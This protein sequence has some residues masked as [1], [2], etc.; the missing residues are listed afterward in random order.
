MPSQLDTAEDLIR[1]GKPEQARALLVEAVERGGEEFQ[2][3]DAA[4]ELLVSA[5]FEADAEH[6]VQLYEQSHR[7]PLPWG[8]T[9]EDI[10]RLVKERD[11]GSQLSADRLQFKRL[12][13]WSRG[14][15]SRYLPFDPRIIKHVEITP[16]EIVAEKRFGSVRL[17]WNEVIDC[18]LEKREAFTAVGYTEIKY[19]KRLIVL[20]TPRD[21]LVIDVS[22][23]DPEF[24]HSDLLERTI[25]ERVHT[26]EGNLIPVG[27]LRHALRAVLGLAVVFG[28]L[29]LWWAVEHWL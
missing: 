28:G 23:T 8:T 29:G 12:S 18:Y 3:W 26:R 2:D 10:S 4:V 1:A 21:Q 9:R 20:R 5:G 25:R 16:E 27:K 17:R 6:L 15:P 24:R 22:S 11:A 7:G 14:M 19:V 13:I